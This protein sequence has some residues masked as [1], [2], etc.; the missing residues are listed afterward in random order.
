M[1]SFSGPL[2]GKSADNEELDFQFLL[3]GQAATLNRELPAVEL[4]ETLV[5]ETQDILRK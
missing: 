3:Y 2:W 5:K 1:Y 4:V